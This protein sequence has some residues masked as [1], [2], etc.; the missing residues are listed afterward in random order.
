MDEEGTV[1]ATVPPEREENG[2][3]IIVP[4]EPETAEPQK[5][6]TTG[7]PAATVGQIAGALARLA[8]KAAA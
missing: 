6:P 3:V 1:T 2:I 7:A 5:N 4:A 8:A